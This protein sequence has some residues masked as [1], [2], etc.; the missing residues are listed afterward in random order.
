MIYEAS[1]GNIK[2]GLRTIQKYIHNF[3]EL[4][5]MPL[6]DASHINITLTGGEE[7]YDEEE[8]K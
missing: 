6:H 5:E 1:R 8:K 4:S 3:K 7:D 2:V